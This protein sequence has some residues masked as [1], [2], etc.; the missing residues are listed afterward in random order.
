MSL[1]SS[2]PSRHYMGSSTARQPSRVQGTGTRGTEGNG[3]ERS[4]PVPGREVPERERSPTFEG[5]R[6]V[7]L[8]SHWFSSL[9]VG[10][11]VWTSDLDL[12]S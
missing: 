11:C 9:K 12:R 5:L 3:W 10:P 7:G 2:G 6:E 8:S 4:I 1:I